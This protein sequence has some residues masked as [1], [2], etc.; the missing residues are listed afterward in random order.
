MK[1][2]KYAIITNSSQLDEYGEQG[3]ELVSVVYTPL[4]SSVNYYLKK[5]I[6]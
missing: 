1:K 3:W 5:R 4:T 2:W 6:E